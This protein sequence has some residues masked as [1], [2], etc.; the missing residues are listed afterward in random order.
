MRHLKCLFSFSHIKMLSEV[1][2]LES[3]SLWNF[4]T[5]TNPPQRIADSQNAGTNYPHW[6]VS[7]IVACPLH[8]F[9]AKHTRPKQHSKLLRFRTEV[10]Q[11]RKRTDMTKTT[12]S[13]TC[14]W[15]VIFFF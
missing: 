9:V 1:H 10:M 7:N 6:S 14:F 15:N 11:N 8:T 5:S 2:R 12:V 13:S 3:S 4:P